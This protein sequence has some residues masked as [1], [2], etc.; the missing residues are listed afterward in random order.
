MKVTRR[1]MLKM[2]AAAGMI[3]AAKAQAQ[4]PPASSGK[5]A[6]ICFR[7]GAPIWQNEA[8]FNE[9]LALFEKNAGVTD[10]IT[11]FTSET[12]PPLPLNVILE[13]MPVMQD[14]MEAARARGYRSG[15]NLL[16]T[17]GH[18]EEN[19]PNSLS[20]EFTPMTDINGA[21]CRGSFCPNGGAM[22]GYIAS[23]YEAVAGA[24]PDYVWIDDDVRLY[25]HMPIGACCFCDTC[26]QKFSKSSGKA[27]TRESLRAAC[28]AEPLADQL[29]LRK[30]Y[31]QHNRGAISDLFRLIEK[32]VH[33]KSPG[34]PLGFMTGDRFFE[35]Y[36]FD[37][38]AGILAGPGRA[39]VLWRPGGGT[40]TDERLESITDKAHDIGRQVSVLP[41]YVTCIQSEL[42]SFP[43]QRLKKSEHATALEAAAYIAAGCTGAAFNV[44]SMYDEP[45]DEYAHLVA[46]LAKARPFLDA[47]AGELGRAAPEGIHSGWCKDTYAAQNPGGPWLA[48]PIPPSHCTEIYST[49]LPAAYSAG[50]ARVTAFA[51][52]QALALREEDVLSALRGGVYL[53]GPALARLH[54]MGYGELLGF[55]VAEVRHIDCIEELTSHPINGPFAG[56][57]RNGRQS[58]W[59]CPTYLFEPAADG[60]QAISRCVNYTYNETAPCCTGVF[61]N[62]EGG[63][64]CAAGYYP[65][66]QLQNLSKSAQLK[67]VMRWLS[68]DTLPAYVSSFHRI[69]LWVRRPQGHIAIALLNAS[70][71]PA[72]NV[73]LLVRT[74]KTQ[75]SIAIEGGKSSA[76]A[77][78]ADGPYQRFVMPIVQ[79]W[80][81]A[82]AVV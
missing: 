19:L 9:L 66:E 27:Y 12:H 20:G 25:G 39:P 5:K 77:I 62:R 60:A 82:L 40:Y 80:E 59:K 79:P 50:G 73:E 70:L 76:T 29:A 56:R 58:F 37:T 65:Y 13:R 2:S 61:E 17:V 30:S 42:E 35:G 10:E 52:G 74:E 28:N 47:L 46:R 45:L 22:R 54:D 23:V 16:S 63:R 64:V 6:S 57:R 51:G 55:K 68:K 11:L 44:M 8:R 53:D 38:W 31:L 72:A 34:M 48:G 75:M 24:K 14:R 21:V 32:T 41:D 26:M 81:V 78:S 71:D 69:N 18:H 43:Y 3:A 49:G 67:S 4:Q 15:I 36:D 7:I 33:A 1:T